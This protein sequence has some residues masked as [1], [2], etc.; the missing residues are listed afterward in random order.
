MPWLIKADSDGQI[1]V[2]KFGYEIESDTTFGLGYV[3]T[4]ITL[5]E[6]DIAMCKEYNIEYKQYVSD[7]PTEEPETFFEIPVVA[8]PQG[9]TVTVQDLEIPTIDID[10]LLNS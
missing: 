9:E 1:V 7:K 4:L 6:N 5:D 3:D 2:G 8:E 10:E